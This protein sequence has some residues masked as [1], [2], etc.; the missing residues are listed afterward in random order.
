MKTPKV[1][2]ELK[3]IKNMENIVKT[4]A[5]DKKIK[6][7]AEMLKIDY[8]YYTMPFAELLSEAVEGMQ[9]ITEATFKQ[10]QNEYKYEFY[11]YDKRIECIRFI[12][13]DYKKTYKN[14]AYL[15]ISKH[16]LKDIKKLKNEW[17]KR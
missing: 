14:K 13:K 2:K 5:E 3:E 1:I 15:L 6:S 12:F 4:I 8:Y 7:L 11:C 16:N 9:E 10:I 17:C